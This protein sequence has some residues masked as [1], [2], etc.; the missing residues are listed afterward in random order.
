MAY[1]LSSAA[2]SSHAALLPRIGASKRPPHPVGKLQHAPAA[3][4]H[5]RPYTP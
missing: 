4:P 2:I 3:R 5:K 1:A